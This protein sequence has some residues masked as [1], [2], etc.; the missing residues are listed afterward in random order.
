MQSSSFACFAGSGK[1]RLLGQKPTCVRK[2]PTRSGF[3]WFKI[4]TDEN[5]NKNKRVNKLDLFQFMKE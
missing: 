3:S 4:F 2:Q 5:F 1:Q